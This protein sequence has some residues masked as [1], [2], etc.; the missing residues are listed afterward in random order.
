MLGGE[1]AV[2]SIAKNVER[3][4]VEILQREEFR[5]D[6]ERRRDELILLLIQNE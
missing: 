6:M 1:Q 2:E 5:A 3:C 4:V